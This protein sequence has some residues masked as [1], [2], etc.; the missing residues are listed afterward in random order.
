MVQPLSDLEVLALAAILRLD[1][2][3]YG[4]SI[5]DEIA[6]RTERSVSIGSLYKALHRL[7]HR[8]LIASYAGEPTAVRGGRAK[9]HFTIEP[10]GRRALEASVGALLRMFDG[11][12]DSWRLPTVAGQPL[13]KGKP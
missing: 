2:E 7:E 4:V 12:G 6:K 5:K 11:L 1:S 8:G 10:E 9:K 3:A 13:A